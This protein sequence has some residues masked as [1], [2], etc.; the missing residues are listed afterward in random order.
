MFTRLIASSLFVFIIS[1]GLGCT[2]FHTDDVRELLSTE[3][4][5]AHYHVEP[6]GYTPQPY[7]NVDSYRLRVAGENIQIFAF[8]NILTA[9]QAAISV[10]PDGYRI[11]NREIDWGR[12]PHFYWLGRNIVLYV[13]DNIEI[14]NII[15][16]VLGS[17]FAGG[18]IY[19]DI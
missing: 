3:F 17:Q 14:I 7:F 6:L 11:A 8:P 18:V 4:R 19:P 13:G 9:F 10:S 1:M 15:E 16:S 12:T 2:Q 5:D